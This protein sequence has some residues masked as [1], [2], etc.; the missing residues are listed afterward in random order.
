MMLDNLSPVHY[1][2]HYIDS[3]F[4]DKFLPVKLNY[5]SLVPCTYLCGFDLTHENIIV[6][7]LLMYILIIRTYKYVIL[8]NMST[9]S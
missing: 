4:D 3:H 8:S 6:V 2:Q 1:I 5:C 7:I 9:Y